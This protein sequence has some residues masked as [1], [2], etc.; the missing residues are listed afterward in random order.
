V[1]NVKGA[2]SQRKS[3]DGKISEEKRLMRPDGPSRVEFCKSKPNFVV[4]GKTLFGAKDLIREG[5][6]LSFQRRR[7]SK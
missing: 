1:L 3:V 6:G 4:E 5:G 7:L 2:T